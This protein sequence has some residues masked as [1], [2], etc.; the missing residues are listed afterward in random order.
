MI[1][2]IWIGFYRLETDELTL[3]KFFSAYITFDLKDIH[4]VFLRAY[5]FKVE[6]IYFNE[7]TQKIIFSSTHILKYPFNIYTKKE[8]ISFV[9]FSKYLKENHLEILHLCFYPRSNF[10]W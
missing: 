8:I 9:P 7:D 2:E 1:R 4:K 5:T 3:R 10:P 6:E